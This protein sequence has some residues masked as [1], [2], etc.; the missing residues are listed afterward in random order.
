MRIFENESKVKIKIEPLVFLIFTFSVLSVLSCHRRPGNING[1]VQALQGDTSAVQTN[2]R[3]GAVPPPPPSGESE[4]E[5]EDK[6]QKEL[7]ALEDATRQIIAQY[8]DAPKP[9][10]EVET[11]RNFQ[12]QVQQLDC[13]DGKYGKMTDFRLDFLDSYP[14]SYQKTHLEDG[15]FFCLRSFP[16]GGPAT[17]KIVYRRTE[18]GHS[19]DSVEL[20]T[21]PGSAGPVYRLALFHH[22]GKD[23]YDLLIESAIDGQRIRRKITERYGWSGTRAEDLARQ[24]RT[25]TQQVFRVQGD[26]TIVLEEER[27]V[28]FHLDR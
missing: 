25:E 23:G 22:F 12:K 10:V 14:N 2:L 28:S 27:T 26:G 24:P 18:G 7:Q 8:A 17:A 20:I 16:T 3:P 21:I 4:P 9:G 6:V 1:D 11:D 13:E 15:A 19:D 5:P